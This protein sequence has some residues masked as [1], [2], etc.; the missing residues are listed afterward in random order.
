MLVLVTHAL[1]TSKTRGDI[2]L[3]STL[4]VPAAQQ[5]PHQQPKTVDLRPSDPRDKESLL[6]AFLRPVLARQHGQ[7]RDAEPQQQWQPPSTE[8][9]QGPVWHVHAPSK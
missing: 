1:V 8:P 3:Y 7:G 5:P 2:P 9:G 4:Q 6:P